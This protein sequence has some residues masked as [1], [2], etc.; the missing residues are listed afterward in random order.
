MNYYINS[1]YG[2][3]YLSLGDSKN[4][5]LDNILNHTQIISIY[6]KDHNGNGLFYKSFDFINLEKEVSFG[7]W[8]VD[9]YKINSNYSNKLF[10]PY[11][12]DV[13]Y[14]SYNPSYKFDNFS[15]V[16]SSNTT[17]WI[18]DDSYYI[19]YPQYIEIILN[20]STNISCI[21]ITGFE[22]SPLG[23]IEIYSKIEN[24]SN[25]NLLA[26]FSG[27]YSELNFC[28]NKTVT[29]SD[30]KISV[31]KLLTDNFVRISEIKAS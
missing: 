12:K 18:S 25:Y 15:I 26:N 23:D 1:S 3:D 7:R 16:D 21:N 30:L 27:S 13:I 2:I 8:F 29:I 10:Y 11:I 28:L 6:P 5:I 4:L 9:F 24:N 17:F 31:L 20:N 22:S 19:G 14:S